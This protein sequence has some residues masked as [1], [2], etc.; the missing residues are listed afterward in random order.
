MN[1]SEWNLKERSS[2]DLCSPTWS[3][4]WCCHQQSKK[5]KT[6][7][8]N[9][10]AFDQA[11]NLWSFHPS[12]SHLCQSA[13]Q[14]QFATNVF[15]AVHYSDLW[16]CFC[17]FALEPRGINSRT[18]QPLF[19]EAGET[20]HRWRE[21]KKKKKKVAFTFILLSLKWKLSFTFPE[22]LAVDTSCLW[23]CLWISKYN[24]MSPNGTASP[25]VLYF[26]SSPVMSSPPPRLLQL[27]PTSL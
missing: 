1:I 3:L 18:T 8:L 15:Q 13:Q 2:S 4:L 7:F 12:S 17:S 19:Y 11:L 25:C 10:R 21:E 5:K 26:F 6:C 16:S 20:I 27:H 9:S 14:V 22:L 23:E 24:H